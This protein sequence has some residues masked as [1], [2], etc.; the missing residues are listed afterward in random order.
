MSNTVTVTPDQLGLVLMNVKSA[1]P[2]GVSALVSARC[3]KTN[4]PFGEIRKMSRISA[5]VGVDYSRSVNLER[6]R[7]NR[8]ETFQAKERKWG[9]K[10]SECLIRHETTGE[11]YLAVRV[12][13]AARPTYLYQ[14]SAGFWSPVSKAQ[15]QPWL[16]VEKSA[17]EAQGVDREVC[18][19]N[20]R[21]DSIASIRLDGVFYRVRRTD[22]SGTASTNPTKPRDHRRAIS[23][24]PYVP[25][26]GAIT[27]ED[28]PALIQDALHRAVLGAV[29]RQEREH[30]SPHDDP[31]AD[32]H[33]FSSDVLGPDCGDK[34]RT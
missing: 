3:H 32:S 5:F 27:K 25:R 2:I 19:R 21:L 13:H 4:N 1:R 34:D 31:L 30:E 8:P 6:A 18:Y 23:A 9:Q 20:Y 16:P 12:L 22:T 26:P 14:R 24:R 15:I 33:P 29:R 7:E 17:A 11:L 28:L 10:L